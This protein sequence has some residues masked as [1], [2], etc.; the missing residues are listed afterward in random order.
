MHCCCCHGTELRQGIRYVQMKKTINQSGIG[1][2]TCGPN[3]VNS[4][5]QTRRKKS[6]QARSKNHS[7]DLK[8]LR[9]RGIY[10]SPFSAQKKTASSKFL[11]LFP[12]GFYTTLCSSSKSGSIQRPQQTH[13]KKGKKKRVTPAP[14]IKHS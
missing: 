5:Q 12:A 11:T 13:I 8:S 1:F 6:T 3:L 4:N 14:W 2:Q 10:P 7:Q 9:Q